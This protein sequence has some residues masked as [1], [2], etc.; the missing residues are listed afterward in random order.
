MSK[1]LFFSDLHAHNWTQFSRT[2]PGGRNSRLQAILDVVDYIADYCVTHEITHC[3]MLGDVFHSRTKIDVDVYSATWAAFKRLS[4]SVKHLFVLRGNHDSYD[5]EGSKH[6]LKSFSDFANVIDSPEL[7]TVDGITFAAIPYTKDMDRWKTFAS[8]TSSKTDFFLFHQGVSTG[9]VGAFNITIKAEVDI[10]DLPY[11][12]ADYCLGGHYHKHQFMLPNVAFIGSPLQHTFGERGEVKG[13]MV[14]EKD[15][16]SAWGHKF[17]EIKGLPKF[18]QFTKIEEMDHALAAGFKVEDNY[19][20]LRCSAA[21]ASRVIEE[22]P[23]INVDVL[24]SK[25]PKK[26]VWIDREIVGDDKKLLAEYISRN[27]RKTEI[28]K[29]DPEALFHIGLSLFSSD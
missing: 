3:F 26:E 29:L 17:I 1:V 19:V 14:F 9:L 13:F 10:E 25:K 20:Q 16:L 22:Y 7:T 18:R 2:L 12:K 6:S 5:V 11:K 27:K 24:P 23:T 21:D 15:A 8:M 4:E 28:Q